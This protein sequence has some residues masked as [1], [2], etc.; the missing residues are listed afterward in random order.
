MSFNG[1]PEQSREVIFSGKSK[2]IS[3]PSPVF[4]NNNAIQCKFQIHLVAIVDTGLHLTNILKQYY[5]K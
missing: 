5:L 2:S 4:N 1:D 3:H